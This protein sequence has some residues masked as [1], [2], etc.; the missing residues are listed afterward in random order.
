MTRIFIKLFYALLLYGLYSRSA[1][2]LGPLPSNIEYVSIARILNLLPSGAE[3]AVYPVTFVLGFVVVLVAMFRVQ[4]G[5]RAAAAFFYLLLTA[6]ANS[7]GSI[8]HSEHIWMIAAILMVF[9]NPELKM[10]ADRNLLV[11]RLV[12]GTL[13]SHYFIS[14]LWKVRSLLPWDQW[15]SLSEVATEQIAAGIEEGAGPG[16]L[17]REMIV[18]N[19]QWMA[20]LF[21]LFVA[22]HLDWSR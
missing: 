5:Y 7:F 12:Q 14:G 16:P 22:E 9:V 20:A 8:G 15:T 6:M 10:G 1:I 13:L 11:V 19:P 18:Q 3:S 21:F 2:F 17:V 4:W